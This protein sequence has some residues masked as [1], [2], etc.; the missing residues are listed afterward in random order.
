MKSRSVVDVHEGI[1]FNDVD[2]FALVDWTGRAMR[3]DKIGHIPKHLLPI[4]ERLNMKPD[5]WLPTVK[6][7]SRRFSRCAGAVDHIRHWC[8]HQGN[9]RVRGIGTSKRFY[10]EPVL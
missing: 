9:A 3:N 10:T 4:L 7:F 6:H 2:Y 5:E 8:Q 1:P